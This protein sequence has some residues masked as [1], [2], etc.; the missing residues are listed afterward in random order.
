M[1]MGPSGLAAII[2]GWLTTEIGRQP[3]VVY[4]V[5]RTAH[6]VSNHSA[7]ALSTTLILFVVMYCAVF[8]TGIGYMLKLVAKGPK[9]TQ[10][11]GHVPGDTDASLRPIRPILA[12]SGDIDATAS[13][14]PAQLEG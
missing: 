5:M 10:E 12:A 2:A 4:G 9:E 11:P 6:A 3:W 14:L 13:A 8:G 7:L 1:V